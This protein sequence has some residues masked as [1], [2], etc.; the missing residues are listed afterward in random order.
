MPELRRA[1]DLSEGAQHRPL[2]PLHLLAAVD[3]RRRQTPPPA[4]LGPDRRCP[5]LRRALPR[6]AAAVQRGGALRAALGAG[7]RRELPPLLP[8]PPRIPLQRLPA[9]FQAGAETAATTQGY[10]LELIITIFNK[11]DYEIKTL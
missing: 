2:R 7:A 6:A 4:A 1:E 3:H 10:L 5:P 11:Y 8:V 9:A